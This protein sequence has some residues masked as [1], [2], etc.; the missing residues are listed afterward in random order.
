MSVADAAATNVV[1]VTFV[2]VA[3]EYAGEGAVAAEASWREK[4]Y[5]VLWLFRARDLCRYLCRFKYCMD[6]ERILNERKF[7]F[8]FAQ[9]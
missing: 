6:S 3:A 9:I 7:S 1:V 4:E 8:R 2:T 5:F